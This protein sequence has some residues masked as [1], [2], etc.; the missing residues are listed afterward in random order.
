MSYYNTTNLVGDELKAARASADNQ[1]E[2]VLGLFQTHN[3]LTPWQVFKLMGFGTITGIRAQ[4]TRLTDDGQ[5]IKTDE[6]VP[7]P[8]GR[9]EHV[10]V[11]A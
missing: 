7:G 5:L 3:K 11:R 9:P 1:R 2:A 4:I 8:Y 6:K 10:W